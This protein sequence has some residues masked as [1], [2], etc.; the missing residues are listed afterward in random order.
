M[1]KK[2]NWRTKR[3]EGKLR[4]SAHAPYM[5]HV[6]HVHKRGLHARFYQIDLKKDGR[7]EKQDMEVAGLVNVEENDCRF[8]VHREEHTRTTWPIAVEKG[9]RCYFVTKPA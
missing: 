7:L 3:A 4:I 6:P 9:C 2:N 1:Y 5:V 8:V